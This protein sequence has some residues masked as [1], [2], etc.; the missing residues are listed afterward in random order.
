M[1]ADFERFVRAGARR[2]STCG[3]D[4]RGYS[5]EDYEQ[6]LRIKAWQASQLAPPGLADDNL[7]RWVCTSVRRQT[8]TLGRMRRARPRP[9]L[10]REVAAPVVEIPLGRLEARGQLERLRAAL[11]DGEWSALIERATGNAQGHPSAVVVAL[12]ARC[13]GILGRKYAPAPPAPAKTVRRGPVRRPVPSR[14]RFPGW[15]SRLAGW[16]RAGARPV[17]LAWALV[18]ERVPQVAP[19]VPEAPRLGA[20]GGRCCGPGPPGREL[21]RC[22]PRVVGC[23]TQEGAPCARCAG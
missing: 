21:Q 3:V 4:S 13:A 2:L 22:P 10:H 7:E 8:A 20:S 16:R 19:G 18:E 1:A 6:E 14:P 15:S 9:Q 17:R 5:R 12:R 23:A 11:E